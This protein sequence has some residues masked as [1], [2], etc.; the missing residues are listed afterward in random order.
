VLSLD[1]Q[2]QIDRFDRQSSVVFLGRWEKRKKQLIF[3]DED[4]MRVYSRTFQSDYHDMIVIFI[5]YLWLPLFHAA[6]VGKCRFRAHVSYAG[7]GFFGLQ[8]NLDQQGKPLRTILSTLEDCLCPAFG[9]SLIFCAAGR[10]DAGVSA[11][12]QVALSLFHSFSLSHY[13]YLTLN[14]C[15]S[16]MRLLV[17]LSLFLMLSLTRW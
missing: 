1:L 16:L 4:E 14:I 8:K 5:I 2:Q 15:S 10:T 12:D 13:I 11:K 7:E 3:Y 17:N 6:T 9:Q